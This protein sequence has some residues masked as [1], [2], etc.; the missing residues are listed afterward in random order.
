MGTISISRPAA[1]LPSSNIWKV[2]GS[3]EYRSF[4]CETATSSRPLPTGLIAPGLPAV[5]KVSTRPRLC[6][7][8]SSCAL[9]G[10]AAAMPSGLPK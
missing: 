4:G 9:A 6:E 7:T 1:G 8:S 3:S 5:T 2:A 10:T